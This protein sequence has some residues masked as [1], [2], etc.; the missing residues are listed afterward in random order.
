MVSEWY[1]GIEH[2]LRIIIRCVILPNLIYLAGF[3]I[4][5]G[6]TIFTKIE[7]GHILVQK[8]KVK[9]YSPY[10]LIQLNKHNQIKNEL[11]L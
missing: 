10:N 6:R 4:F 5:Y 3:L 1:L 2:S 11:P 7:I 8:C 9:G